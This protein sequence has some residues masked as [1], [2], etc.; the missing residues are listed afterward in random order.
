MSR[1]DENTNPLRLAVPIFIELL[2]FMFMGNV[3]TIMLSKY[4]DSAVAA[5]GNANQITNTLLI[6]FNITSAATGIMVAQ[7]IGASKREELNKIYTLGYGMNLILALILGFTFSIFQVHFFE[8]VKM[9]KELFEDAQSYLS[10]IMTF[11]FVPAFFSLSSVILKSHGITKLSM[12]LAILMNIVNVIGNYTFLFGPFGLPILG[13]KGVA[14]STVISRSLAVL[15]MIIV[16]VKNLKMSVKI[17]QLLPFPGVLF[18][19]FMKLGLPSA[20]EPISYQFSQMVIFTFINM[21]GTATVTTKVYVQIIVWFTFLGSM[22]IAQANQI[23]VG[24]LVGAGKYD[25]AYRI[26]M[27][28]FRQSLL[29]TVAISILFIILR[30]K[31]IGIFSTNSEIVKLGASILLIDLFVEVGRVSNLVIISALKAAGDV[32]FPV[33]VGIFSMWLVS[34]LFAYIL[35]I[36]FGLGLVGIWIAMAADEIL[37]GIIMF[38]RLRSGKWRGKRIVTG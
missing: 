21:M 19:Q 17:S 15:I 36:H 1:I 37:R 7:Y 5:V 9:P 20:G 27:K 28:S 6:L 34:T 8:L 23:V 38:F 14:I 4:S 31:L 33:G 32:N 22:A 13:V 29:Y 12:Y 26:T 30:F 11:L 35:G 16:L 3:D 2:L 18:R 24:Q 10:V 25:A